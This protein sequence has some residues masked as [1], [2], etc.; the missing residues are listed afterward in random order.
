MKHAHQDILVALAGQPNSGKSTIFQR[1]TGIHQQVA[2]YA[3]VTVEKKSG[4]YH[5]NFTDGNETEDRRVELVDLPGTYSLTSYTQEERVTR[6]F[7]LLQSPEVVVVVVDASNLQRH[8][9]LVFQLLELQLPTVVCLNM[10]DV[11][12]RRGISVDLEKLAA[13]LKTPVVSTNGATGEG[14]ETLRRAIH[15]A[16]SPG[17]HDFNDW[18]LE[19]TPDFEEAVTRIETA[20]KTRPHLIED[21]SAR[22]LAVKLLEN[23]ADARRIVQHHTHE[24]N[25]RELLVLAEK[26]YREF[27]A[28]HG[29]TPQKAIAIA[30]RQ[31]ADQIENASVRRDPSKRHRTSDVIDRVLCHP[32]FGFMLL[33][34]IMYCAF[35][36]T[37]S[38]A[39]GWNWLP[40][41]TTVSVQKTVSET[42]P[43]WGWKMTT[44]TGFV[45]NIFNI[46][47]PAVLE[48][49]L[50]FDEKSPVR[51]L[52]FDGIVAGIGGVIA[53][54][55]VIFFMFL[56]LSFLEHTGYIARVA[57]MTD[58]VMRL[59]GLQGQSVMPLILGG[60]IAGGCAVPAIMATRNMK[61]RRERILTILVIPFMNCGAKMPVYALLVAAFFSVKWQ[62]LVYASLIFASWGLALACAKILSLTMVR[63]KASPLLLE[64]PAYQWPRCRAVIRT[65][66]MQ[67]WWFLKKAGTII[68][69]VNVLLWCLMYYPR[70]QAGMTSSE[71]LAHSWAGKIGRFFEPASRLAGFDWRDNIALTG[72]FVAKEVIVASLGTLYN[73]GD[74]KGTKDSGQGAEAGKPNVT[75]IVVQNIDEGKPERQLL[76][77]RL[78]ESPHWNAIKAYAMLLFVMVYA[79]CTATCVVICRETGFKWAV[80]ALLFNTAVAF[81]IAVVIYQTGMFV[82]G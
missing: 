77:E 12:K 73:M 75:G 57:M 55:P 71:H 70:P 28:E 19:Y 25:W 40:V 10:T 56:I 60:G 17:G 2:N 53:F 45:E 46:Q 78:R 43:A 34:V 35:Q 5:E 27:E 9:F 39:G 16:V 1:L 36:L 32:V 68:L 33:I 51:S 48:P 30:R 31:F 4:H 47:L 69:A 54:V 82:S 13:M 37:F 50:P 72:G 42:V 58:R 66:L 22:W 79:P 59:F 49:V 24:D 81:L 23:D 26:T 8:L 18:R 44:P 63:G 21:F 41:Y 65:A 20:L 67:S 14:I 6:D 80:T 7:L 74:E 64:L 52:L 76:G 29:S 3:G 15:D 61:D 38:L 62:G 11:A